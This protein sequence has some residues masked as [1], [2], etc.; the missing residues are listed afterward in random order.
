MPNP[1]PSVSTPAGN[2]SEIKLQNVLGYQLAQASIVTHILFKRHTGQVLELRPVEY[3]LLTL[4]T[5]N[6]GGSLA[7][8]AKAL[9]VTAP[10]IT[11][12]V[13]RLEQR[14][15][16]VREKSE[17][18]KRTQMLKA[19]SKG[20]KLANIATAQILAHEQSALQSLSAQEQT[21]LLSLLHKVASL[22]QSVH[23]KK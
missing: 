10:N 8:L 12:W 4:I 2:L 6:P 20:I 7:Q 17:S 11:A 16:V 5:E 9:A 21:T 1:T 23:K 19:T 13:D 22:R 18:D 15:L 14:G 3:T